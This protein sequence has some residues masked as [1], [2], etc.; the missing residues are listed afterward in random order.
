MER[1]NLETLSITE[2]YNL[3]KSCTL[4]YEKKNGEYIGLKSTVNPRNYDLYE[5]IFEQMEKD[6]KRY[7]VVRDKVLSE[8][9]KRIENIE[10]E[11]ES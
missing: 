9:E 8:L 7:M 6:M 3:Q 10:N 5:G 4:L 11:E 2:L 1:I